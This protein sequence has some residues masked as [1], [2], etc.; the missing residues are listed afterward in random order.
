MEPWDSIFR[1]YSLGLTLSY[2]GPLLECYTKLSVPV[3]L[4]FEQLYLSYSL[5][6]AEMRDDSCVRRR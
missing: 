1:A 3:I 4:I 2:K 6:C 5:V